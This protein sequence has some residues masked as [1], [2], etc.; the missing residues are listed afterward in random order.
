MLN[1]AGTHEVNATTGE[2]VDTDGTGSVIYSNIDG[3]FEVVGSG[4]GYV[5]IEKQRNVNFKSNEGSPTWAVGT[6]GAG[7]T[8]NA[9]WWAV[10]GNNGTTD[11]N[12]SGE[13]STAGVF[14]FDSYGSGYTSAPQIVISGGGWRL[15]GG[16]DISRGNDSIGASDG[17]IISR[18]ASGGVQ[19]FIEPLNP[20]N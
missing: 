14:S 12:A 5:V 4:S 15:S 8:T 13:V 1:D 3:S 6:L 9:Q 16:A 19:A 20:S 10:G 17:L 11:N 2:N 18:R 7:Y